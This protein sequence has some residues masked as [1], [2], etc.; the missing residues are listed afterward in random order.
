MLLYHFW[1]FFRSANRRVCFL[2]R[3]QQ[4]GNMGTPHSTASNRLN[5]AEISSQ[6]KRAPGYV[7]T[8]L[9]KFGHKQDI[10]VV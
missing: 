4:G 8:S 10:E 7:L 1:E 2:R 3:L 9:R 5:K 6:W